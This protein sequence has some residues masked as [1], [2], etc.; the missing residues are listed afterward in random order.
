MLKKVDANQGDVVL[1]LR[2]CG[3]SV[4]ITSDLGNG[5]VDIVAGYRGVNYLLQ[6]KDGDQPPS[7]RRLTPAE[8]EWHAAW[9][10]QA[11]VV[12]SVDEALA[13]VGVIDRLPGMETLSARP[14][15]E[16]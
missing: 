7:K 14:W 13:A 3:V 4:T 16:N 6:I 2:Q 15:G 9:R 8:K 12:N 5:F 1:A 10:G 11:F